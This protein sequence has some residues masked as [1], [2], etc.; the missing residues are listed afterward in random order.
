MTRIFTALLLS[1]ALAAQTPAP[2]AA[3]PTYR[4][5]PEDELTIR[6]LDLKDEIGDQTF[7]L[8]QQGAISL[9]MVGRIQAGG[10]TLQQLEAYIATRFKRF[11]RDPQVNVS[12]AKFRSQPVSVLGY[13]NAPG[14]HQIEE[15]RVGKECRSRWSPYH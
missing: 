12:V 5:G 6:V 4:L 8:D 9:P 15:R 11:L 14:V 3:A 2:N 7:R 13:V 1:T 10:L